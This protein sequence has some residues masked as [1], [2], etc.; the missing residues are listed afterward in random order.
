MMSSE[1]VRDATLD[2]APTGS[3]AGADPLDPAFRA[4]PHPF[5]ARLRACDPVNRTPLGIWRLTRHADVERLLRDVPTGV[6]MADGGTLRPSP[7]TGGPSEFMLS[8]DP[9]NHTRLRR[10]VSSAF[11]P[12]AVARMRAHVQEIV[13]RQL[14]RVLPT[15]R[16]DV[17][18][19]LALPVPSTVICEMMNVP[20]A[21]RDRFTDWT[22]DA[23]HLL[24]VFSPPDVIERGVA[25]VNGLREYFEALIAQRRGQLGDDLLSELIRAEEA[26]DRLSTSELVA[27]SIGL[28]IAG[29]ETTI[30][31]I[32]NGVL[33]LLRHPDQ[34]ALL[35]ARPELIA[36][37]V[38]ECLRFD[39][40]ILL[41]ARYLREDTEFGG[42]T[43][44]RD[45]MV[46]G[47]LAAAHRDPAVFP[48]PDRFDITRSGTPNLAFGGGIHYCLGAHLARME[49]QAAIGSLVARCD[50]LALERDELEWGR[51]LFRVLGSLPVRF[52]PRADGARAAS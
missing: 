3:W 39:G 35:R 33:A 49:A 17:I 30:G 14:A 13:D 11:T 9:P 27:Q 42:V 28:L 26:G 38:E 43:I 46:W 10:L 16:M 29:F 34:L 24:A 31:L 45:A 44:P 23:T 1:P 5:L 52:R 8:Q 12:N 22:A 25:A 37:A 48:D 6:R 36:S 18:A 21:D 19:D 15:G 4:D 51:S 50:D 7:V 2:P 41:T 32:G 40:P 20:L 47:M